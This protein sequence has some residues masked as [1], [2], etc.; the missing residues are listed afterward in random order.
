MKNITY[1]VTSAEK[2]FRKGNLAE[3]YLQLRK[4]ALGLVSLVDHR[5]PRHR[6]PWRPSDPVSQIE[7]ILRRND[8]PDYVV[9]GIVS[10]VQNAAVYAYAAEIPSNDSTFYLDD[11]N[12]LREAV[13]WYLSYRIDGGNR[14]I[15]RVRLSENARSLSDEPESDLGRANRAKSVFLCH[16]KEDEYK[17]Q[18]IFDRLKRRGHRPWMDI[19]SLLPGEHW[20]Q[21]IERAIKQ[22][23][24]F[25]A[26]LS[27]H[28]VNKR[29]FVQR[30]LRYALDVLAEIPPGKIYLIPVRL[31][32]CEI[33]GYLIS[34]PSSS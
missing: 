9:E 6:R 18:I 1:E 3:G 8:A 32:S 34:A 33:P 22:A 14:E 30:E 11:L 21:E 19:H 20:E 29:G 27:S 5:T 7:D 12:K 16:A 31:E 24:Y 15:D 13:F 26:C 28:S 25:I 10:T 17:A 2:L 4:A 23:D